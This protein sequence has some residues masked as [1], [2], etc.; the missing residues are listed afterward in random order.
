MSTP[1]GEIVEKEEQRDAVHIATVCV[2]STVQVL[3]GEHVGLNRDASDDEPFNIVVRLKDQP[4][5]TRI[6]IADPFLLDPI[7]PFTWFRVCLYPN[8]ITG[9]NHLWTHPAF[10][11]QK[12]LEK[13]VDAIAEAKDVEL[14]KAHAVVEMYTSDIGQSHHVDVDRSQHQQAWK[15]NQLSSCQPQRY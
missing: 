5:A 14:I 15:Q 6:G 1:L 4:R 8:T 10:D 2:Y 9:L 3:P 12:P 11:V 7:A 13:E